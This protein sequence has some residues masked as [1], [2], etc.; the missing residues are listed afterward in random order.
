LVASFSE[1][2]DVFAPFLA[3]LIIIARHGELDD[4]Q[5]WRPQVYFLVIKYLFVAVAGMLLL[6][7]LQSRLWFCYLYAYAWVALAAVVPMRIVVENQ[8]KKN[9][10]KTKNILKFGPCRSR[11]C[12]L[13]VISTML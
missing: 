10:K 11:T 7:T 4:H 1:S 12:D 8:R 5:A 6:N 9:K 13:R 3:A 2:D